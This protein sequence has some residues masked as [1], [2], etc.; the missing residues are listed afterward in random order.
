MFAIYDEKISNNYGDWNLATITKYGCVDNIR[1]TCTLVEDTD[2]FI[3]TDA[4]YRFQMSVLKA[5]EPI[6]FKDIGDNRFT[7]TAGSAEDFVCN[8]NDDS[9]DFVGTNKGLFHIIGIAEVFVD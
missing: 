8:D 3:I 7:N 2:Q 9:L 6:K 5:N 4:D 1:H